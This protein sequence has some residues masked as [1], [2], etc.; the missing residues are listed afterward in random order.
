MVCTRMMVPGRYAAR[1]MSV[2]SFFGW[3]GM[4]FGAFMGGYLYDQTGGYFWAYSFAASAGVLNFVVLVLFYQRV[5]SRRQTA[6]P[7]LMYVRPD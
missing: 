4:G 1:A 3:A 5:Q 6:S 2:T 7:G